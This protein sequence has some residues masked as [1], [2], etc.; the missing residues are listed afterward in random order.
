MIRKRK[1]DPT[2]TQK[3]H[4]GCKSGN[5]AVARVTLIR[6]EQL[7]VTRAPIARATACG[8]VEKHAAR[9]AIFLLRLSVITLALAV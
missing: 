8:L 7:L 9:S 1:V 6:V 3:G 4:R 2:L 5:W